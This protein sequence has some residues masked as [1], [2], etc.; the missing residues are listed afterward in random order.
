MT[1]TLPRALRPAPEPGAIQRL[2]RW[3]W[4]TW[5]GRIVAVALVVCVLDRN[6]VPLPGLLTGP[7]WVITV[8][9]F[10]VAAY[11]LFKW[12]LRRWLWR[13][14]TKLILSYL[15]V[16]VVPLVL[17]VLFFGLVGVISSGVVASYMVTSE[18]DRRTDE[19]G[20]AT[21]PSSQAAGVGRLER[22]HGGAVAGAPEGRFRLTYAFV[23]DEHR[24]AASA[25][26]AERLPDWLT[27][28]AFSGLVRDG[29]ITRL[30]S[31][32]RRGATFVVVD[33]PLGR[34]FLRTSTRGPA[35][36]IWPPAARCRRAAA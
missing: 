23:R 36:R 29:E 14:R 3:F 32:A 10:W 24:V 17:L 20:R 1:T 2:G 35:S 25:T 16:A 18:I 31:V 4:R 27:Q 19:L 33:V 21:A 34:H 28:D 11:R 30:R 26:I 9:F 7:A 13:I 6:G 15:F 5:T 22:G 12:I 8:T